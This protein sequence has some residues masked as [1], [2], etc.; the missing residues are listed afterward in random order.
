MKALVTGATPAYLPIHNH[1]MRS[2]S[3]ITA[4][5]VSRG[6]SVVVLGSRLAETLFGS[7]DPVG[8]SIRINGQ[9]FKVIGVLAAKG[10]NM[11]GSVDDGAVMP[12]TTV[13]RR[14][15][16]ERSAG[17]ITVASIVIQARD[18]AQIDAGSRYDGTSADRPPRS[19]NITA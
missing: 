13:A 19:P 4:E 11:F 10:G 8:K 2:G 16:L 12:L 3:F 5:Q 18:A 14:L 9:S 17:K 6:A 1:S 15:G 7:E